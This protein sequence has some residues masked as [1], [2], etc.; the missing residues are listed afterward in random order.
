MLAVFYMRRL[1]L[2]KTKDPTGRQ[3]LRGARVLRRELVRNFGR[4]KVPKATASVLATQA[5][6]LPAISTSTPLSNP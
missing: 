3:T 2:L 1:A 6:G 4:K 5:Y